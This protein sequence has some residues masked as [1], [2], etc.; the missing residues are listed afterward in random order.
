M[1]LASRVRPN[2]YGLESAK[3]DLQSVLCARHVVNLGGASPL[4]AVMTGTARLGKG[5]RREAESEGSRCPELGLDEQKPD[6]RPAWWG[7]PAM[8]GDARIVIRTRT[9]GKSGEARAKEPRLTL[10]DLPSVRAIRTTAPATGRDG[11][12][13]V[14]R[15]RS[16]RVAAGEVTMPRE[17]RAESFMPRSQSETTRWA[18]SGSKAGPTNGSSLRSWR[19]ACATTRPA[20]AEPDLAGPRSRK[21]PRRP[22]QHE[23]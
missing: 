16:S 15:G 2:H 20:K 18:R 22:T 11:P 3:P 7:N 9:T 10:G 19:R 21:R 8:D 14:S 13:E 23:P 12:G 6:T 1:P 5:V 17:R 4:R